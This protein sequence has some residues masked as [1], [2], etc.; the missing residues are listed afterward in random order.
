MGT[1]ELVPSSR[2]RLVKVVSHTDQQ[3]QK[4]W[5]LTRARRRR[6]RRRG[7][8]LSRV[9]VGLGWGLS[10]KDKCIIEEMRYKPT[11]ERWQGLARL[12]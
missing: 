7:I 12:K 4:K 1:Q 8:Y 9:V 10:D 3:P 11:L 2:R 5:G 6:R